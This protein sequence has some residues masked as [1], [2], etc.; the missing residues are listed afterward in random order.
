MRMTTKRKQRKSIW[1]R[2]HRK[3]MMTRQHYEKIMKKFFKKEKIKYIK[4]LGR[5]SSTL[6]D[7]DNKIIRIH[8][9]IDAKNKW[10]K[11]TANLM[12]LSYKSPCDRKIVQQIINKKWPNPNNS[13]GQPIKYLSEAEKQKYTQDIN[14]CYRTEKEREERK[15]RREIERE[16]DRELEREKREND[17]WYVGDG[18]RGNWRG[19]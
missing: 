13:F 8:A 19:K 5:K 3:T 4:G 15:R 11:Y 2:K 12:N 6:D 18:W 10:Y 17:D 9:Q 1:T 14:K 7:G 16:L